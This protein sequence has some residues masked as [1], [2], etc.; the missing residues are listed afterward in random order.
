M[1]RSVSTGKRRWLTIVG[2]LVTMLTISG[3]ATTSG[4]GRPL[5]PFDSHEDIGAPKIAGSAVY[6]PVSQE[7]SLS[8]GGVNM[9]AQR[10][11][12]HFVWKRMTGDFILQARVEFLGQGGRAAPQGRLD[13]PAEPG[14]RRAIR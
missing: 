13:D 11:E 14:Y 12:F 6:N 2:A 8:A 7:Y 4:E 3:S 10:D 1:L 5:G 9:W